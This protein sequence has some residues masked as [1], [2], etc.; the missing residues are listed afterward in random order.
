[1]ENYSHHK[2][3]RIYIHEQ[4]LKASNGKEKQQYS[5]FNN[6]VKNILKMLA[7]PLIRKLG[8]S[9]TP[10]ESFGLSFWTADQTSCSST[11]W[12]TKQSVLSSK[13]TTA[14]VLSGR[15]K[16]ELKGAAK[17]LHTSCCLKQIL[18]RIF[19]TAAQTLSVLYI[20]TKAQKEFGSFLKFSSRSLWYSAS[21]RTIGFSQSV[22]IM[23]IFG[24]NTHF[25][26]LR[27]ACGTAVFSSSSVSNHQ[28][29]S[30][31]IYTSSD[32]IVV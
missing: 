13:V 11:L 31:E 6:Y 28:K 19:S 23:N 3:C 7:H 2:H 26:I 30:K 32:D 25:L 12:Y 8:I 20:C 9:A 10:V 24:T 5:K 18:S 29:T 21:S 1:M 16:Q 22:Y 14:V 15:T 17:A 4:L 27:T